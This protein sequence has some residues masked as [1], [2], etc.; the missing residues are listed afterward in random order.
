M[1]IK[2]L[3]K[4]GELVIDGKKVGTDESSTTI[5]FTKALDSLALI[6]CRT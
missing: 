1:I 6:S 4:F 2:A 5:N 3:S